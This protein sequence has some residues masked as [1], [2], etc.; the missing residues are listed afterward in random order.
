M[1]SETNE[2]NAVDLI[3]TA[4]AAAAAVVEVAAKVAA[5]KLLVDQL[6]IELE[7]ATKAKSAADEALK[8]V[9]LPKKAHDV[10]QT[11]VDAAAEILQLVED[12]Q[13]IV[14]NTESE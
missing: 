6:N 1:T 7:T 4:D 2:T 12:A 5:N 9:Q 3:R 11:I 10:V 8:A 13:K 14:D